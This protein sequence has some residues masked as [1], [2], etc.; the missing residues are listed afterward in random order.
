[1]G[2]IKQITREDL[3]REYL[4]KEV[5]MRQACDVLGCCPTTLIKALRRH[6]LPTKPKTWN[7]RRR[8]RF[9]QLQDRTW[10]EKQLETRTMLDIA[11]ELGTSS[12]NVSDHVRRHGLRWPH[13]DRIEAVKEGI[14]KAHPEGRAGKSASNWKGGKCTTGGGHVYI[15]RPD[16]PNCTKEGYVMEHRLVVEESIGRLL[17]QNEVVHHIN[18]I[19]TDNRPE[20]LQV[21]TVSGHRKIHMEAYQKLYECQQEN[22]KLKALIAALES[23]QK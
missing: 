6:G 1:M 22:A 18:G 15:H 13:Y 2:T 11:K 16:H 3:E 20:N 23:A 5:S 7:R 19:K 10:L 14:R 17:Q 8:T 21:L 4:Q 9:P 12:G